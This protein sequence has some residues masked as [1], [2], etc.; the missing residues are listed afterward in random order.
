MVPGIPHGNGTFG[1]PCSILL[2]SIQTWTS[3]TG[4]R[5]CILFSPT[6]N[7]LPPLPSFSGDGGRSWGPHL[8]PPSSSPGT[9]SNVWISVFSQG[10]LPIGLPQWF[11]CK[12]STCNAEDTAGAT[13]S[14][15]ESGRS[16]GEGNGNLL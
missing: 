14:V 12:E 7:V 5:H 2:H 16:P 6:S 4:K 9:A 15:S 10:R 1:L 3:G 8:G 13:G 11:S